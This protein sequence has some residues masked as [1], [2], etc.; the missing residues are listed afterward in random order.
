MYA[1]SAFESPLLPKSPAEEAWVVA[2]YTFERLVE[3]A[4]GR[5]GG[6]LSRER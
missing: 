2:A 4:A 3:I 1:F 6:R 5:Q